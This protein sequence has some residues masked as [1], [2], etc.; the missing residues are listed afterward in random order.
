MSNV[1]YSLNHRGV[2]L[3]SSEAA[4]VRS[5]NGK[6]YLN[7]RYRFFG[8]IEMSM[9]NMLISASDKKKPKYK[10]DVSALNSQAKKQII[11]HFYD[12]DGKRNRKT[13]AY[14]GIDKSAI[15]KG[16]GAHVAVQK[17]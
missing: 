4:W 7:P 3:I 1:N 17:K 9:P 2:R 14:F 12:D 11:E 16:G 6:I 10:G 8:K 15:S 13:V 5:K